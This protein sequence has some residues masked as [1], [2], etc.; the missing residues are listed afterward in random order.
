MPDGTT[1]PLT[2]P[3]LTPTRRVPTIS[4]ARPNDRSIPAG[5]DIPSRPPIPRDRS[6]IADRL[7][8]EGAVI[9]RAA[10]ASLVAER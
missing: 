10:R 7:L 9:R 2:D 6:E 4:S 5:R 1:T 3:V 8:A